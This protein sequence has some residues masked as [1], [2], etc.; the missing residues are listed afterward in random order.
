MFGNYFYNETT[1]KYVSAFGTLFN[2][3]RISRKDNSDNTVQTMTVPIHYGPYQKFLAKL[4]QDPALDAPA[5]TLPRMSFEITNISY[6]PARSLSSI[7]RNSSAKAGDANSYVTQFSAIPYN[8]DIQLS[9]MTKYMEDGTKIVEQILPFFTPDFTPKMDL[10]NDISMAVDVPI[11][12]NDISQ[13]D[14]Y[15]SDFETRRALIWTL[16]FTMK[17]YFFGPTTDKKVIKFAEVNAYPRMQN[18]NVFDTVTVQ[19]GLTANGDPTTDVNNTIS[20]NDIDVNDN[21]D[22]IVTIE[23]L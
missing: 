4:D 7:S 1:R 21:W 10:M 14:T 5:I 18:T 13:E 15:E 20:Y 19:P 9:V 16:N 22:Y 3:I 17:A 8:I 11:I 2:D 6:D 12:L 23:D